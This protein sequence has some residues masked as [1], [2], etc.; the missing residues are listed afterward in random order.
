MEVLLVHSGR[1]GCVVF[2]ADGV[3]L[4]HFN[5]VTYRARRDWKCQLLNG[6]QKPTLIK[7]EVPNFA[8]KYGG[9]IDR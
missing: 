1:F 4:G 5:R 6:M 8:A 3:L 7:S 2:G 9:P